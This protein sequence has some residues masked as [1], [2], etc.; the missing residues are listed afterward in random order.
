M[1]GLHDQKSLHETCLSGL[2]EREGAFIEADRELTVCS[3]HFAMVTPPWG[4][5]RVSC[6][7]PG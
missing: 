1:P 7:N 5:D 4:Y 3:S 2:E 6:Q